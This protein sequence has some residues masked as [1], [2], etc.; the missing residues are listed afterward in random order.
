MKDL[1][2]RDILNRAVRPLTLLAV[3]RN[4]VWLFAVPTNLVKTVDQQ[5]YYLIS[6]PFGLIRQGTNNPKFTAEKGKPGDY[7]ARNI[8]GAYSLVTADYYKLLFPPANANPPTVPDNSEKLKDSNFLTNILKGSQPT[9]SNS[10][11]IKPT[12]TST[13]Y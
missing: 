4:G 1:E 9:V 11:T 13:G 2:F 10:K 5:R 6:E 8:K 12:T 7:V 3:Y